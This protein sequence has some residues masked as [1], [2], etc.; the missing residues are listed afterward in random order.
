MSEV[1]TEFSNSNSNLETLPRFELREPQCRRFEKLIGHAIK[2]PSLVLNMENIAE[3]IGGSG[4][5]S[6]TFKLRFE[7]A[8][9]GFRRYKYPS[10]L[11]PRGYDLKVIKVQELAGGKVLVSNMVAATVQQMEKE[12]VPHSNNKGKLIQ[13]LLDFDYA[14]K[15]GS[16]VGIAYDLDTQRE[17]ISKLIK[18]V[19]PD[20]KDD[21]VDWS[22]NAKMQVWIYKD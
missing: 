13:F 14:T 12:T 15:D 21:D 1:T 22:P 3:V 11:I 8:L 9:L 16:K 20:I 10:E 17:E 5:N 6:R 4:M 19:R 18:Q 7:D 2:N